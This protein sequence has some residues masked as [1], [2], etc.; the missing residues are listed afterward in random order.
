MRAPP[1]ELYASALPPYPA[2]LRHRA[3]TDATHAVIVPEGKAF[4]IAR[5]A[6]RR[7]HFRMSPAQ[8]VAEV[9][10]PRTYAEWRPRI[11]SAAF[12]PIMAE[13]ACVLPLTRSGMIEAS[14]TRNPSTPRTRNVGSTTERS[15]A[16]MRQVPTG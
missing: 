1:P 13:G 2:F 11:M 8:N 5:S 16:P 4:P 7:L 10:S 9:T 12:S 14:A 6:R 15:S 3:L